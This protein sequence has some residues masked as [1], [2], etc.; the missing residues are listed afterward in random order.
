MKS[1]DKGMFLFNNYGGQKYNITNF[2]SDLIKKMDGITT[3]NEIL[4]NYDK[5]FQMDLEN[6]VSDLTKKGILAVNE[7][8]VKSNNIQ[9]LDYK[10]PLLRRLVIH[11]TSQCNLKC[12]HCYISN[13]ENELTIP[14]IDKILDDSD[15]VNVMN[16][17]IT[18]GEPFLNPESL[19]HIVFGCLKKGIRIENVFSNGLLLEKNENLVRLIKDNFHTVFYISVDGLGENY[20]DFRGKKGAFS[21]LEK[22]L[23][24][25][26][27]LNIPLFVNIFINRNNANCLID[28]YDYVKRYKNFQRIR[29]DNGFDMGDWNKNKNQFK[30]NIQNEVEAVKKLLIHWKN[31]G[32]KYEFEYG[33]LFRYLFGKFFKISDLNYDIDSLCCEYYK[34][35]AILMPDGVMTPCVLTYP[36][37]A[38]GDIYNNSIGEMWT[39]DKMRHFKSLKIKDLNIKECNNCEFLRECGAG[40]RGNSYLEK[41]LIYEIDNHICRLYKLGIYTEFNKFCQEEIYDA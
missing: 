15:R 41:G 38:C 16:F 2:L 11:L 8:K 24:L 13:F 23:A 12:K 20:D 3:L 34:D 7:E 40:C 27:K 30:I 22:G 35:V 14:V 17:S 18:G 5:S 26:E 37:F 21:E 6:N 9:C 28:I 39:S 10:G 31:D 4:S 29:I 36:S 32:L 33:H 1:C 19:K 25:L